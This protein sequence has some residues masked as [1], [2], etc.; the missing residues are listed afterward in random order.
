[1]GILTVRLISGENLEAKDYDGF[2]DP[3]CELILGNIK[4]K[5]KTVM[6]TLNPVWNQSF[7]FKNVT[8]SQSDKLIILVWDYDFWKSNDPLGQVSLNLS[9]LVRGR[10]SVEKVKLVNARRGVITVEL[11]A[12]DFGLPPNQIAPQYGV[13]SDTR[14]Q[15]YQVLPPPT[16]Q[17]QQLYPDPSSQQRYSLPQ[18][19]PYQSQ[20]SYSSLP[21]N[22]NNYN[23]PPSQPPMQPSPLRQYSAP[24]L[25]NTIQYSQVPMQQQQQQ[26]Q[27]QSVDRSQSY[28][29]IPTYNIGIGLENASPY[30]QVPSYQYQQPSYPSQQVPSQ[31]QQYQVNYNPNMQYPPIA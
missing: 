26:Q 14:N 19:Q 5:S 7:H 28:T 3:F 24:V 1:M 8:N 6:K 21:V 17:Q 31:S 11:T 22:Q 2:S 23:I 27:Q 29:T 16:Q 4:Y 30:P 12:V 20:P 25:P 10:P 15:Q 13:S 9:H 18:P